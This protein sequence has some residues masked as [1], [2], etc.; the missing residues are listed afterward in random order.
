MHDDSRKDNLAVKSH[1]IPNSILISKETLTELKSGKTK[2]S[3][4]YNSNS[5]SSKKSG[6]QLSKQTK[7]YEKS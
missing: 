1:T 2:I 3:P 4:K 5:S 7:N 6:P